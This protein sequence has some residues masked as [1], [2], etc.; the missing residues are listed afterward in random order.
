MV[1]YVTVSSVINR[2]WVWNMFE[3]SLSFMQQVALLTIQHLLTQLHLLVHA[4]DVLSTVHSCCLHAATSTAV[5]EIPPAV[6]VN[7]CSC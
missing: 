1:K 7:L 6:A 4:L 5:L 3:N 2:Q